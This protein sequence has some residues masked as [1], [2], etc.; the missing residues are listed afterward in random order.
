MVIHSIVRSVSLVLFLLAL[1]C[2][3]EDRYQ[4]YERLIGQWK[5]V[6]IESRAEKVAIDEVLES[7]QFVFTNRGYFWQGEL[8]RGIQG[9]WKI[10]GDKIQL[11][12]PEIKDLNGRIV[13]HKIQQL[14]EITLSEEWMIWRGTAQNDTQHLKILFKKQIKKDK[15]SDQL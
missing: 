13:S 8:R 5:I 9:N 14:W 4:H 1:A 11:L 7:R 3:S 15:A 12:Q 6:T 10:I 2:Q